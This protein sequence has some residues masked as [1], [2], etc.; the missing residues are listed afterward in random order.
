MSQARSFIITMRLSLLLLIFAIVSPKKFGKDI[1]L[2]HFTEA[3]CAY[4]GRYGSHLPQA[5]CSVI[6]KVDWSKNEDRERFG[7]FKA[8]LIVLKEAGHH[9]ATEMLDV[10][11]PHIIENLRAEVLLTQQIPLQTDATDR[12]SLQSGSGLMYFY[13]CDDGHSISAAYKSK[14][15]ASREEQRPDLHT[16]GLNLSIEL[17]LVDEQARHH[18]LEEEHTFRICAVFF[19]LF[20]GLFV[21]GLKR[22][23]SV[24]R[25]QELTDEPLLVMC[26]ILAVLCASSVCKMTGFGLYSAGVQSHT[27]FELVHRILFMA[28]DGLLCVF[29]IMLSKGWGAVAGLDLCDEGGQVLMGIFL[30]IARYTWCL[31]GYFVEYEDD[32]L[33]HLYD[34]WSGKLEIANLLAFFL[35]FRFSMRKQTTL[36]DPALNPYKHHLEI[37]SILL[38]LLRP[39]SIIFFMLLADR[40][41]QHEWGLI[42]TLGS[43][44]LACCAFSRT[45][46]TAKGTYMRVA[47]SNKP[48]LELPATNKLE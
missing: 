25:E 34:G 10:S 36:S 27:Y 20:L 5:T 47:V 18:S 23:L 16:S 41:S 39:T 9:K 40:E 2:W 15:Q 45:L 4:L 28:G 35:W 22:T 43:S 29:L 7:D 19:G 32:D 37:S 17:D 33:F 44:W 6:H 26:C 8:S 11:N 3:K 42:T 46:F 24:W 30:L 14:L 48:A 31:I 38:Y 13:L 1:K 12:F 21:L